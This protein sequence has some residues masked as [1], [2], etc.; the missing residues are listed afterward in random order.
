MLTERFAALE[1]ALVAEL[2]RHYGSRLL[3][4]VVFGSVGRGVPHPHSDL[5]VL[6]VA[7]DLPHGRFRR[8]AEFAPVEEALEPTIASLRADGIETRLSPV[9]KTPEEAAAGSPLFLDFVDDARILVDVGQTFQHVLDRLKARLNELG[10]RRV[11]IGSAWYW[12]LK[13]DFK[14][15][16]VF[17]L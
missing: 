1:Q 11:R 15:G 16:E 3:S 12:D 4:V 14:P 9:L 8:S 7:R 10:A 17:E 13:P 2:R 5:D 6:V